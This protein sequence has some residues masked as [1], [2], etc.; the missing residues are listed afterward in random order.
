[1]EVSALPDFEVAGPQQYW[2]YYGSDGVL[3]YANIVGPYSTVPVT[4]VIEAQGG[5]PDTGQALALDRDIPMDN[6]RT[7][8]TLK[9]PEDIQTLPA[10]VCIGERIM[11]VRQMIRRFEPVSA[12][13]RVGVD[14][15][16]PTIDAKYIYTI[17]PYNMSFYQGLTLTVDN[18]NAISRG[19]A[20]QN[21]TSTMAACFR[22]MRGGMRLKIT[23]TN[24]YN[25]LTSAKLYDFVEDNTVG[26]MTSPYYTE[27][28]LPPTDAWSF[29]QSASTNAQFNRTGINGALEIDVPFYSYTPF[30][31]THFNNNFSL[32][33]LMYGAYKGVD[34]DTVDDKGEF[35]VHRATSDD[36]EFGFF[37]G[38]PPMIASVQSSDGTVSSTAD[39]YID[40]SQHLYNPGNDWITASDFPARL[41]PVQVAYT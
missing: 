21:F 3:R 25:G 2:P 10:Q 16:Y 11:S 15:P 4:P 30:V 39:Y 36:F 6:D 17:R 14:T 20:L 26:L 29:F 28:T 24:V 35:L 19:G 37:T 32:P 7:L 34:V 12:P 41:Q 13:P 33:L 27:T 18:F 31:P 38:F 22:F 23:P 9:S 40:G 8:G 5:E 1:M